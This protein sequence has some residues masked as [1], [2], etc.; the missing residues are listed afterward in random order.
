MKTTNRKP[1][2]DARARV[3]LPPL[4][5]PHPHDTP[6]HPDDVL[7]FNA[8]GAIMESSICNVAFYRGGR[9]LTPP[10]TV[11]CIPGVFRR[12]LLENGRIHEADERSLLIDIIED[13]EWVLVFNGVMG[14][15]LGRVFRYT[16]VL[17]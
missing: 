13:N 3:G 12:W 15:R 10:L 16:D 1:Y 14:C 7:L 4:G 9:W 5:A 11:G 6:N 17:E 8:S 2:D